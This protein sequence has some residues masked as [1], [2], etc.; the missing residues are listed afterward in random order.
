MRHKE[1]SLRRKLR[2][3][4]ENKII[5]EKAEDNDISL[6]NAYARKELKKEDV[7][8]FS[9]ILCDNEVD[10]D[11]EVFSVNALE[12][13]NKLFVGKTGIFDHD[14]RAN[15]QC[16]RIY[17]CE[18]KTDGSRL[19]ELGEIYT[20][21]EAKAYVPRSE[22]EIIEKIESGILKEVSVSC[23]VAKAYCS[24]CGKEN[25]KHIKGKKYA[26][27]R[28]VR[29]LDDAFDAYEFSFV[30]IPAQRNAGVKKSYK[31]VNINMSENI[32]NTDIIEKLKGAQEEISLSVSEAEKLFGLCEM[33]RAYREKLERGIAKCFR[34]TSPELDGE[35]IGKMAENLDAKGLEKLYDVMSK[36]A[37]KKLP[38]EMNFV[39]QTA[40]EHKN[41]ADSMYGEYSI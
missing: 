26:N 36:A 38:T 12:K 23:S 6:I 16:A 8:T 15:N 17:S 33:G 27:K 40:G 39:P 41:K 32:K 35:T 10:R 31:G 28:A 5:S 25:C 29:I 21:L 7:Y 1:R 24:V 13:L 11:F 37:N 34:V 14:A 2:I 30:A 20:Y 4:K 19:T 3:T 22:E 18:V 9:V